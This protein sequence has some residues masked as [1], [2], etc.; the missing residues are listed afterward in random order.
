MGRARDKECD[1]GVMR[2]E[3]GLSRGLT[4]WLELGVEG[5]SSGQVPASLALGRISLVSDTADR[6]WH[7]RYCT[8]CVRCLLRY[9][10]DLWKLV[11]GRAGW[12]A[13]GGI[14]PEYRG[15]NEQMERPVRVMK[16]W[17]GKRVDDG[18]PAPV[19]EAIASFI[20]YLT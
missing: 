20:E 19:A 9:G 5:E 7:G 16:Y 3:V 17:A 11:H 6:G 2:R 12:G 1:A 13:G 8:G 18:T 15:A 10:Q 14:L 4:V